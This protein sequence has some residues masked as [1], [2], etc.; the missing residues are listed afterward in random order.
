[1]SSKH[2]RLVVEAQSSDAFDLQIRTLYPHNEAD[3]PGCIEINPRIR[4][5]TKDYGCVLIV[6]A[7][8]SG[9]MAND[10]RIQKLRDGVVRL[11]ELSG[12]FA[13]MKVELAIIEFNDSA[14]LVLQSEAIPPAEELKPICDALRPRGGTN[15]GSALSMAMQIASDDQN[16]GKAIHVAL[17]TDG[18]DGYGLEASMNNQGYIHTMATHP[19][20]WVHCIGICNGIDCKLLSTI[21]ET[22]RRGTFQYIIGNNIA[23]LMGSMW[24]L[25]IEAIDCTCFVTISIGADSVRRDVV[26]RVCDPPM[27]CFV[28]IPVVRKG[29][30]CI[31][32]TLTVGSTSKTW[33]RD[34]GKGD[35]QIDEVV[36]REFIADCQTACNLRV[37]EALGRDDFD[38][39]DEANTKA[40]KDIEAL[41]VETLSESTAQ[42]VKSVLS[43]LLAQSRGIS[44]ARVNDQLARDLEAR[45]M[46]R[47]STARNQ[48]VSL[49]PN[50]RALSELQSQLSL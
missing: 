36:V 49:D 39:A 5:Q 24:G 41:A 25:M 1:M 28:T 29:I 20:L 50:S 30:P 46:S 42:F 6:L 9:S 37:A 17:F 18:E 15:I 10:E 34:L 16:E 7:D 14:R 13:S 2:Q 11:S 32:A 40:S 12:R 23:R 3:M 22:A 48:G 19:M 35:G 4:S 47:T 43:D 8:V 31:T 38:A 26:L 27:P 33:M 44:Y 21:S 45:T